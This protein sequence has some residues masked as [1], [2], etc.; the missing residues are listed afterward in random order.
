MT[1]MKYQEIK[2]LQKVKTSPTMSILKH[3]E[4]LL[5]S[6]YKNKAKERKKIPENMRRNYL[7]QNS[8]TRHMIMMKLLLK[9]KQYYTL[10]KYSVIFF[11]DNFGFP[12]A[13]YSPKQL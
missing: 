10:S 2:S 1:L 7:Q 11:S 3:K 9:K 5:L 6:P 12:L 8:S 4:Q 13:H